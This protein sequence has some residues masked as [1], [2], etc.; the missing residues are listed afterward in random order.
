[1]SAS[2]SSHFYKAASSTIFAT[3]VLA[4]CGGGNSD[5]SSSATSSTS[6]TVQ[7]PQNALFEVVTANAVAPSP[8]SSST[9][10]NKPASDTTPEPAP[11]TNTPAPPAA[12]A[13]VVDTKPRIIDYYGDSTIYGYASGIGGQVAVPAPAAFSKALPSSPTYTVRNEG[14][15]A[16]TACQ[17]L[18]GTDGVHPA[19]SA[20][21][22]S[23]NAG[24]VIINHAINDEWKYDVATY[25]S[26]MRQLAQTAKQYGKQVIF[27]TP[28]PTQDTGGSIEPY[29]QGMK[30]VAT[31]EGVPVIDQYGYLLS[32]LN[33][34]DPHT[35]CPDGLHPTDAV[36]IMKGKYAASAFLKLFPTN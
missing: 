8:S 1:M 11:T 27:E 24:Y 31:Q 29:V 20:Q 33:G 17:L 13:P 9:E 10:E 12:T 22:E 34:Q 4:A 19:W 25:K 6:A 36:Y 21:M 30:D 15:S 5:S 35:I 28:N 2:C 18:K 3:L 7:A 16:T 14:V 23:S 26:C 32:Y